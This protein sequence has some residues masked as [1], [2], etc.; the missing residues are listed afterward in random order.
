MGVRPVP[1]PL[2]GGGK[3]VGSESAAAAAAAATR[4]PA[5]LLREGELDA[6]SG[7]D[8]APPKVPGQCVR[9]DADG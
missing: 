2:H 8:A 4:H 1:R 9:V 5:H 7:V 3:A 6:G